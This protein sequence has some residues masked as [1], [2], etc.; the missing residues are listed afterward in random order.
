MLSRVAPQNFQIVQS[1]KSRAWSDPTK[2]C[3]EISPARS[4]KSVEIALQG[5]SLPKVL[6]VPPRTA[7]DQWYCHLGE[8]HENREQISLSSLL[9]R[10]ALEDYQS[11]SFH[12]TSRHLL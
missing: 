4:V 1:H 7:H 9:N 12:P 5:L 10:Q 2:I 3:W 8:S 11:M 6:D